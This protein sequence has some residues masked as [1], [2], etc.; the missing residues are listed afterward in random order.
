ME[1]VP[2]ALTEPALIGPLMVLVQEKAVPGKI[3]E[4]GTKFKASPLQISWEYDDT[5]FVITGIG[6]TV[7]VTLKVGPGHPLA[8]G[9]IV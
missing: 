9:V 4:V 2:L 1:P 6:L 5:G 3:V 8:H 7:A